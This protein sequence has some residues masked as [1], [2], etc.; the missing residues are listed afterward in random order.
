MTRLSSSF[1]P[2][3]RTLA[4]CCGLL[5]CR[6][7]CHGAAADEKANLVDRL[8]AASEWA[9]GKQTH[10]KLVD[11]LW[12]YGVLEPGS[13][14][15]EIGLTQLALDDLAGAQA[16]AKALPAKYAR[17]NGGEAYAD[18]LTE[19]AVAF[20][21][22]GDLQSARNTCNSH[23]DEPD[24][25]TSTRVLLGIARAQ[26]GRGDHAGARQTC[27][28]ALRDVE[29]SP[30]L[31]IDVARTQVRIGDDRALDTLKK[32]ET[33]IDSLPAKSQDR[34][35]LSA[36]L[37]VPLALRGDRE[38]ATQFLKQA[39]TVLDLTAK[40]PMQ[41]E[42]ND[43]ARR[44]IAYAYA[45]IGDF[46]NATRV[47]AGIEDTWRDWTYAGIAIAQWSK[48]DLDAAQR[49]LQAGPEGDL[50]DEILVELAR[51]R[52]LRADV[53]TAL[54][55]MRLIK[56]DW[57]RAQAT[58]EI[59]ASMAK[60]G[61]KQEAQRLVASINYL[62]IR[63]FDADQQHAGEQLKFDLLA[64]WGTSTEHKHALSF[65]MG[66]WQ[67][68]W[69]KS[70][71]LLAA[72][73]RC[74]TALDGRG[75]VKSLAKPDYWDVRK[76][77]YAQASEGDAAGALGWADRLPNPDRIVALL[78]AAKGYAEHLKTEKRR[79]TD[80]IPLNPFLHALEYNI[81]DRELIE[82]RCR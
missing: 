75:S 61:K 36:R 42:N 25:W 51:A 80:P 22:R 24:C 67:Q 33:L 26:A 18:F 40:D 30:W 52:S 38:R 47:A 10:R 53:E 81:I 69:R 63:G 57:R 41:K 16:T 77:A 15:V 13:L 76:A 73:V 17:L 27:D 65:S 79:P 50:R 59:A 78:G 11:G 19:L 72:A 2:V 71:D 44:W 48:C 12:H 45:R 35:E 29:K 6:G 20:V 46:A 60:Q 55:T 64:K 32:A 68:A 49:T 66:S 70:G 56:D 34:A 8:H 7:D 74:R 39:P 5:L 1:R 43:N 9:A 58:L 4:I 3:A 37:A 14:L 23:L 21:R 62:R 31:L 54:T 28:D 82:D